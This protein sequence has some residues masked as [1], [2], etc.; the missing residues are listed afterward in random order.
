MAGR[1]KK[2]CCTLEGRSVKRRTKGPAIA[3]YAAAP[4]GFDGMEPMNRAVDGIYS[5]DTAA[6]RDVYYDFRA[7]IGEVPGD[8]QSNSSGGG[9]VDYISNEI[10]SILAAADKTVVAI[11]DVSLARDIIGLSAT[12]LVGGSA[13][14]GALALF[15]S[16]ASSS[17]ASQIRFSSDLI[18]GDLDCD[19][20]PDFTAALTGTVLLGASDVVI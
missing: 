13:I 12:D 8:A 20:I 4:F 19:G 3:D 6:S 9:P 17:S 2:G 10:G 14:D 1:S 16:S 5:F 11:A 7:V 15:G 18:F